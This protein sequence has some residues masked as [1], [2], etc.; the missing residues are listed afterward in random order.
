VD[1]Y[2]ILINKTLN[3]ISFSFPAASGLFAKQTLHMPQK[4]QNGG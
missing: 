4:A 1:Y 3:N 2:S